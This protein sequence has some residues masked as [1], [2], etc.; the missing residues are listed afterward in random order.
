MLGG[1]WFAEEFGSVDQNLKDTSK[2]EEESMK[3]IRLH[4][5]LNVD[6]KRINVSVHKVSSL[7]NC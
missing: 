3:A 7:M 6:P 5:G 2:L 4:L 1:E